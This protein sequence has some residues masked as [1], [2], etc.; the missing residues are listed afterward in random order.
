MRACVRLRVR[1]RARARVCVWVGV[2]VRA[3]AR[4]CTR[5]SA[6]AGHT[7][8]IDTVAGISVGYGTVAGGRRQRIGGRRRRVRAQIVANHGRPFSRRSLDSAPL[9]I[10]TCVC[11]L[12]RAFVCV[13][14][15]MCVRVCLCVCEGARARVCV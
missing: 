9:R 7:R 2:S 12:A 5:V 13:N 11:A 14:V 1:A 15:F 8:L 6:R 4:M 3:H 10:T